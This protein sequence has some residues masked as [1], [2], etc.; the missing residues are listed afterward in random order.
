MTF[1]TDKYIVQCLQKQIYLHSIK[2]TVI[3]AVS[4][5]DL[6][7]SEQL[8]IALISRTMGQEVY[9]KMRGFSFVSIMC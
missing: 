4:L 7:P 6:L 8:N 2:N 9:L 5:L 3:Q 1:L